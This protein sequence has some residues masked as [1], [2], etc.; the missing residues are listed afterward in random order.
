M[1]EKHCHLQSLSG[2]N[3][4]VIYLSPLATS[5]PITAPP[6]PLVQQQLDTC[7]WQYGSTQLAASLTQGCR[8]HLVTSVSPQ[9]YLKELRG[10]YF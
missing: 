2:T 8:S 10:L 3:T 7:S 6:L 5:C 4:A 1:R 9:E